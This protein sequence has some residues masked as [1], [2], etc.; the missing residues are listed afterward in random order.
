MMPTPIGKNYSV[1]YNL[2]IMYIVYINRYIMNISWYELSKIVYWSDQIST[3]VMFLLQRRWK[4]KV[5]LPATLMPSAFP[6]GLFWLRRKSD[7]SL[8]KRKL[9]SS[10]YSFLWLNKASL[11]KLFFVFFLYFLLF[12]FLF[13]VK[14]F[15]WATYTWRWI[16]CSGRTSRI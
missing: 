5:F 16:W 4:V 9:I 1:Y 11:Q 12:S 10:F 13:K 3:S 14:I 6:W 7:F 2:T 15:S 8:R